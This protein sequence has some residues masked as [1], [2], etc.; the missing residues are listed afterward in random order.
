MG[1]SVAQIRAADLH[2]AA[3]ASIRGTLLRVAREVQAEAGVLRGPAADVDSTDSR[4]ASG[5]YNQRNH[6][7]PRLTHHD[8]HSHAWRCGAA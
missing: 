5:S 6:Y 8:V 2:A 7:M 4:G 1:A 3:T